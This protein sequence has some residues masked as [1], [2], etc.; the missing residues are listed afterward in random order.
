MCRTLWLRQTKTKKTTINVQHW[1][2]ACLSHIKA[3]LCIC[4]KNISIFLGNLFTILQTMTHLLINGPLTFTL[5]Y[6]PRHS[7]HTALA[8]SCSTYLV[9]FFF[10]P[11]FSC[12]SPSFFFLLHLFSLSIFDSFR[13]EQSCTNAVKS[14]LKYKY[15][16]QKK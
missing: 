12:L 13:N 4:C 3:Y 11:V 16:I 14:N 10:C 2:I 7:A 6:F 15:F 8:D 1:K 5:R 9:W